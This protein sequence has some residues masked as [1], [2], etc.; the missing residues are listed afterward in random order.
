[1][2]KTVRGLFQGAVLASASLI[3]AQTFADAFGGFSIVVERNGGQ[4]DFTSG[5]GS[6]AVS[7]NTQTTGVYVDEFTFGGTR[8]QTISLPQTD[9]DGA[10]AQRQF[11]A[12]GTS[13]LPRTSS[14]FMQL[15][16]DGRYLMTGGYDTAPGSTNPP[17]NTIDRVI[18]RVDMN[19][20]VDTSTVFGGTAVQPRSVVSDDGSRFWIQTSSNLLFESFG[21]T[22]ATTVSGASNRVADIF[23]NRLWISSTSSTVGGTG[24]IAMATTTPNLPTS[25]TGFAYHPF[26]VQSNVGHGG[27]AT[28][29]MLDNT[30]GVG[31]DGSTMDTMYLALNDAVNATPN[32]GGGLQKWTF[33]GTAWTLQYTLTNGLSTS[34][35]DKMQGG[36]FGVAYA[37]LDA[38]TGLPIFVATTVGSG[39]GA[40]GNAL[41]SI[42]DSGPT[43]TFTQIA[44]S[45]DG[46]FF[47]G[48]EVVPEPSSLLGVAGMALLVGRRRRK[49]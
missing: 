48:V 34:N 45:P 47:R 25:G 10:G 28:F 32:N 16:A 36:L 6:L 35:S 33:D 7:G 18:A 14:Q 19:G 24:N 30:P 3:A 13:N 17:A 38:T 12:A 2:K 26:A 49:S 41:V 27:P 39:T 46:S 42:I 9:P 29:V 22:S 15:S 44:V 21:G 4:S 31:Y 8:R 1:M 43:S 20:N 37:G 5:T 11:S 40:L 23:D